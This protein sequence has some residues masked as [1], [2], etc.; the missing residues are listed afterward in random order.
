MLDPS[1]EAV[2]II[3]DVLVSGSTKEGRESA[4]RKK[5]QAYHLMK[6]TSHLATHMKFAVCGGSDGENHMHLAL[7][8]IAMALCIEE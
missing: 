2:R 3:N 5:S 8:R 1:H 6:A 4:W 7:T